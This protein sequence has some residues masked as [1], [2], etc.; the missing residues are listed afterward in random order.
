MFL[1]GKGKG[2][3][4]DQ[5]SGKGSGKGFSKGMSPRKTATSKDGNSSSSFQKLRTLDI[6]AGCGGKVL[7]LY[8]AT[9]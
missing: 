6:F 4:K 5:T 2:K 8:F 9:L 7:F 1:K 3:S